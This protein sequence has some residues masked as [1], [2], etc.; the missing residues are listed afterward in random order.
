[1]T[2]VR[3]HSVV[4]EITPMTLPEDQREETHETTGEIMQKERRTTRVPEVEL[5]GSCQEGSKDMNQL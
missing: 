1:M 5:T 3:V 4:I 2:V